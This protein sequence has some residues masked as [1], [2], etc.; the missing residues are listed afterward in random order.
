MF[1]DRNNDGQKKTLNCNKNQQMESSAETIYQGYIQ[2][3]PLSEKLKLLK[4]L[5]ERALA[6]LEWK[7]TE[8]PEESSSESRDPNAFQKLLLEGPVMSDEEYQFYLEKKAHFDEG[9]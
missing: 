9:K 1:C 7:Y 5:L 2:P 4:L 8:R 3:L 6:E